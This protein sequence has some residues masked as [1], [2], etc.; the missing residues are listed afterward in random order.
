[1]SPKTSRILGYIAVDYVAHCE[2]KVW[3]GIL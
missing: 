1:M 2:D 3:T